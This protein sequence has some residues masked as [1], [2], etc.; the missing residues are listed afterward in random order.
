VA[1]SSAPSPVYTLDDPVHRSHVY[2]IVAVTD[3]RFVVVKHVDGTLYRVDVDPQA[4][5]GRTITPID[6]ATVRQGQ[7]M[8]LE[9]RRLIVADYAGVSVVELS[10]D[11][12]HAKVVGQLRDPSFRATASVVHVGDR[13]LVVNAGGSAAPPPD[14]VASVPAVG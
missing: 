12:L 11:M 7:G 13:Y 5:G 14:T 6:G 9:G 8:V 3:S 2:G 10:A 1:T 4:A